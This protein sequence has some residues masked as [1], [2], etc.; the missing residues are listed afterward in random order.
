[1]CRRAAGGEVSAIRLKIH[2]E[3]ALLALGPTYFSIDGGTLA[4]FSGIARSVHM[5]RNT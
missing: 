2:D 3:T 4:T 5:S 1:M